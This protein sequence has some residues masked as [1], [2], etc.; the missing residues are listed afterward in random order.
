M[1]FSFAPKIG[2]IEADPSQIE[3]VILNLAINGRDA[4]PRG[5]KLT[6]ETADVTFD[7]EYCRRHTGAK[8]G[9][10]VMLSITDTGIG[11]EKETQARVFEPFFTT[12]EAGKGTGLGLATVYGIVKQSGGFI[13]LYSE[14]GEGTTFKVY[15]PRVEKPLTSDASR[16][17]QDVPGGGEIVL[18][19][20]DEEALRTATQEFLSSKGY[21]VFAAGNAAEALAIGEEQMPKLDI[22]VTDIVMPGLRGPELAVRLKR[23]HPQLRVI[24]MSGYPEGTQDTREFGRGTIFLQKPFTLATLAQKLREVL[25]SLPEELA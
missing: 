23:K 17:V 19:V 1:A 13:W 16:A 20:E 2:Q 25:I 21:K 22:V 5:G 18:L 3:Q 6:I 7:E 15:L 8:P 14:P 9:N 4:M 12:K 10:Y 24:Y 11:M